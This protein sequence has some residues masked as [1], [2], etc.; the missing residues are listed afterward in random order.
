MSA[1]ERLKSGEEVEDMVDDRVEREDA[2]IDE[3]S[4]ST[5]DLERGMKLFTGK[6]DRQRFVRRVARQF[7]ETIRNHV[8][9]NEPNDEEELVELLRG[10]DVDRKVT[11]ILDS[12]DFRDNNVDMFVPEFG[13]G[14]RRFLNDVLSASW[15][16]M[17]LEVDREIQ[18]FVRKMFRALEDEVDG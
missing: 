17:D 2:A 15:A 9:V 3:Q 13:P 4:S 6:T 1:L 14:L 18:P 16:I 11:E 5:V 12:Q 7:V 8:D 10:F